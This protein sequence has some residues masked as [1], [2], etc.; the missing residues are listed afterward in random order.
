MGAKRV[1]IRRIGKLP[2]LH[3][4]S[5]D[6]TRLAMT[7]VRMQEWYESANP[8]FFGKVFTL[9][10]YKK[11]YANEHEGKFSYANDWSGFNVPSTAVHIV[12][13]KFPGH[14][15][16]EESLFKM[17]EQL[18]VLRKKRFYLIG[19]RDANPRVL[20]HEFRHALYFCIQGYRQEVDQV[21]GQFPVLSLRMRLRRM[22]YGKSVIDDEIQAWA[23]TGWPGKLRI[24]AEMRRMKHALKKVE[25][26]YLHLLP[27]H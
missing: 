14:S 11:W 26:K 24:S 9:D 21:L 27:P 22:G 3:V 12:L 19:S 17:L 8:D 25:K 20:A 1:T 16:E 10:E 4:T 15:E 7:F 6:R 23:L 2:L 13:K 18:G 5:E